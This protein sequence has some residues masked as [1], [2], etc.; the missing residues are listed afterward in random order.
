MTTWHREHLPTRDGLL[1]VWETEAHCLAGGYGGLFVRRVDGPWQEVKGRSRYGNFVTGLASHQGTLYALQWNG[2]LRSSSDGERWKNR[3]TGLQRG[4]RLRASADG[5]LWAYAE[6]GSAVVC[7]RDGGQSFHAA[8]LP[9]ET[10]EA[11]AE[12]ARRVRATA[13]QGARAVAVGDEGLIL[14]SEDGGESW[15]Q[16]ETPHATDFKAACF[17]PTGEILVVGDDAVFLRYGEAAPAPPP[18]PEL[19]AEEWHEPPRQ[20]QPAEASPGWS[21]PPLEPPTPHHHQASIV[22][23]HFPS[24]D[25]LVSLDLAGKLIL[26]SRSASG[27]GLERV[28]RAQSGEPEDDYRSVPLGSRPG[29]LWL[30]EPRRIVNVGLDGST[31]VELTA[32]EAIQGVYVRP[33]VIVARGYGTSYVWSWDEGAQA[34]SGPQAVSDMG[35][36]AL[37]D[38]SEDGRLLG[39]S[40]T[41]WQVV[42]AEGEV[43]SSYK[44]RE[45]PYLRFL[46]DPARAMWI[47]RNQLRVGVDLNTGRGA[48]TLRPAVDDYRSSCLDPERS[49]IL[50]RDERSLASQRL[51]DGTLIFR[52][53]LTETVTSQSLSPG[54]AL[55]ALGTADGQVRLV[56][57]RAETLSPRLEV[58]EGAL[59]GETLLEGAAGLHALLREGTSELYLLDDQRVVRRLD[60]DSGELLELGRLADEG[61]EGEGPSLEG[62]ADDVLLLGYGGQH[63]ETT[64]WSGWDLETGQRR[65]AGVGFPAA[66]GA[67]TWG[68]TRAEECAYGFETHDGYVLGERVAHLLYGLDART[69]EVRRVE[70]P[71]PPGASDNAGFGLGAQWTPE[72]LLVSFQHLQDEGGHWETFLLDPA[73]GT[74]RA[75]PRSFGRL[76]RDGE[77]VLHLSDSGQRWQLLTGQD[78][79]VGWSRGGVYGTQEEQIDACVSRGRVVATHDDRLRVSSLAGELLGSFETGQEFTQQLHLARDGRSAVLVGPTSVRRVALP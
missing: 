51:S 16:D 42:S 59:P 36:H 32:P 65:W 30:G 66:D 34:W 63:H 14:R 76:T 46:S 62:I 15:T 3:R 45:P 4:G 61:I 78:E 40:Q 60:L 56:G 20:L 22:G 11:P 37:W 10:L 21:L 33:Q 50:L 13:R 12:H 7:S 54:G 9:E 75:T 44:K 39:R 43:L 26:W 55:A 6:Y 5:T 79:R 58:A 24:P 49:A 41:G 2:T 70:L 28:L 74:I 73:R 1:S 8:D 53:D 68:A 19:A 35:R 31:R 23:L 77:H 67:A 27:W 18:A 71:T 72:G 52:A 48:S 29:E 57:E 25:Y 69:G 38:V 47:E 17:T 64:T